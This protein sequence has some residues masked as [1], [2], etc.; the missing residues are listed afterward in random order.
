MRTT[1]VSALATLLFAASAVAAPVADVEADNALEKREHFVTV[2]VHHPHVSVETYTVHHK[3][4]ITHYVQPP[5]PAYTP[6]APEDNSGNSGNPKGSGHNNKHNNNNPGTSN[7]DSSSS[8][9]SYSGSSGS[10]APDSDAQTM[11]DAHN[12]YRA[13]HSAPSLTWNENLA[14]Y[15]ESHASNCVFDHTGGIFPFH[16][17][18]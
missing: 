9:S 18:V 1:F 5:P 8:D 4:T 10:G 2:T 7:T 16:L 15:A 17:K 6:P 12:K 14:S 3:H 11:L 13:L